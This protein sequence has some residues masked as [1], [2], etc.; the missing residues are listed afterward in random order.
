VKAE[1]PAL[2]REAAIPSGIVFRYG[3]RY[4]KVI[5]A[6][7]TDKAAPVIVEEVTNMN[8]PAGQLSLWGADGVARAIRRRGF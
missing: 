1:E 2:R 4:L 5:K 6:Y 3:G 7:G 8:G